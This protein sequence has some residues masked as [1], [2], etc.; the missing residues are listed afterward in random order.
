MQI[1]VLFLGLEKTD[2]FRKH[3]AHSS[4]S[5]GSF[6]KEGGLSAYATFVE[7]SV[8][9]GQQCL[10]IALWYFRPDAGTHPGRRTTKTCARSAC[11]PSIASSSPSALAPRPTSNCSAPTYSC[12]DQ[13]QPGAE[14][15]FN[16]NNQNISPPQTAFHSLGTAV[17]AGGRRGEP[18]RRRARAGAALGGG[19]PGAGGQQL[20]GVAGEEKKEQGVLVP[21]L[22]K[23]GQWRCL[24]WAGRLWQ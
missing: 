6:V 12:C 14:P 11:R 1:N 16:K 2:Y 19:L 9:I 10:R 4:H 20:S 21:D 13:A 23:G 22:L 17:C 5:E 24:R 3:R 18:F 8:T 7:E 15:G